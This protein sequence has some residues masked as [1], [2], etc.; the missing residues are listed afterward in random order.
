MKN[1]IYSICTICLLL[2]VTNSSF[3]QTP[4]KGNVSGAILDENKKPL[5]FA[6][7]MLLQATD[8]SLV[9]G[10]I[11]DVSGK[12]EFEN[13]A[14]GNY[15]VAGS[16]VGYKKIYTKAFTLDA[17]H[18]SVTL[19][20]I[21]MEPDA[22]HLN[23]VVVVGQKPFIEQRVDKMVVNVENSIVSSGGTAMEVLEKAPGIT[24]D[25]DDKISLKGK[26]GVVIM[27]DGKQTY[28]SATE[29]SNMLRNMQSNAI[30]QIE[31]I[32]NPSAK[33]DAAGNSGIIN[34]KLKKNKNM[35]MN[36]NLT[37]GTGYGKFPKYNGSLNLN[38]RNGKFNV[39]GNYNYGYN[40]RFSDQTILRTIHYGGVTTYFD[41]QNYR[42]MEFDNHSFKAGA[43]YY[44]NK[45]NTIG[46]LANGFANSGNMDVTN[47]TII[48]NAGFEA[49]SSLTLFN[50][51]RNTWKSMA[52]NVN[53]RK[54]FDSTDR[55]FSI[56]LDYSKFNGKSKDDIQTYYY[57]RGGEQTGTPLF[58]KSDIPSQVD[59]KSFK[60]DYV[61]P[62]KNKA[63]IETGIKSS[64]VTTDNDVKFNLFRDF[65]W[66][67]DTDRTN[68]FKYTEN[69]NAAYV[70]FNKELSKK[71]SLQLGLRA[72]Q[73]ISRGNSIT[74]NKVVDRNY[75]EWFPSV[76]VSQNISKD[77]QV[78]Y[79]YSRRIDR[80]S[81]Q[82]LNPF[83]YF[84]DP[85]TFFQG[86]P[87]LKPQFT[88]AF[89]VSHTFKG[90]FITTLGY[91]H[92]KDIF[93]QVTKQDDE[94]KV[95]IATM[96]N[97]DTRYN[98]NM[99]LSAPITFTKW[100]TANNNINVYYNQYTSQYLGG[101]LNTGQLAL[102]LNSNH[103]FILAND[104]SA[105]VSGFYNSPTVDGIIKIQSMYAVGFGI[106]KTFM[107]KKASLKLN[108]NDVFNI[109]QFKGHIHYQ[110]MDLK[111]RSNWESRQARL[112]FNYRFGKNDINPA[113]RRSSATES[114]QN[115][116]KMG[117][118]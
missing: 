65:Q 53:Y 96:T 114:E 75:L 63:K 2:S 18:L 19:V 38:Y 34:I 68:H 93:T 118:N 13:V 103:N 80:P 105:E 71:W 94:T 7:M 104:F 110:N 32:S 52:Y 64:F 5:E 86:N 54:T 24:I 37:A 35:G 67:I 21:Q 88:N 69:I 30:E 43:D 113:R 115:R 73:T 11:S 44:I 85:Y 3:A 84:L 90:K 92:T 57:N 8:S 116:I 22:Q 15:L 29:V 106:Q 107:N 56:D 82:D 51:P 102:N 98:Y 1:V 23:E 46:F 70:N 62:L 89:Q 76:F 99:G 40:K 66:M 60:I 6:T 47:E 77:H 87:F 39:F 72:E 61:H 95:T 31:I 91:S 45:H 12:F 26:Q 17:K 20:A 9:K 16:M 49:D 4:T 101:Q 50:S 79:S 28:L 14:T 41:S 83:I 55:E 48:R 100:W 112:T 42:L 25:K 36:G 109:M 97:L 78:N 111:I 74:L 33:Y 117:G 27:I 58:L 81:Y 108:V 59:I 10:A